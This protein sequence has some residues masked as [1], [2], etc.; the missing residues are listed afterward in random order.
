MKTWQRSQGQEFNCGIDVIS[1]LAAPDWQAQEQECG[2][3]L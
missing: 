3:A 1:T 2:M